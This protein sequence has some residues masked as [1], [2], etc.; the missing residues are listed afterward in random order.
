MIKAQL[1]P[2]EVEEKLEWL[3]YDY[4][5]HLNL[6]KLKYRMGNFEAILTIGSELLENLVKINWGD[7]AKLLFELKRR[8][9]ELMEAEMKSPGAEVAYIVKSREQFA[10]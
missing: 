5:R 7:A 4:Q 1:P 6:H 9:I 2:R 10:R 3:I 8:R